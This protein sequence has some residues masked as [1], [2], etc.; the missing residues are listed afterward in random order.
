MGF[1]AKVLALASAATTLVVGQALNA[2]YYTDSGCLDYL[3]R[4]E[5]FDDNECYDFQYT[6]AE[7]ANIVQYNPND[8]GGPRPYC[9]FFSQPGCQGGDQFAEWEDCVSA[10]GNGGQFVSM[11][12]GYDDA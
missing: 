4:I 2:Q 7:S 3:V 1:L 5:P 11:R 8:A 6:G 12:C 10:A 9:A